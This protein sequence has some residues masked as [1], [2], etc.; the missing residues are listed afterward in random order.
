[1]DIRGL[2]SNTLC[3]SVYVPQPPASDA[4]QKEISG[5]KLRVSAFNTLRSAWN[6]WAQNYLVFMHKLINICL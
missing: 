1:M 4:F 5:A 3:L 2:I 6:I